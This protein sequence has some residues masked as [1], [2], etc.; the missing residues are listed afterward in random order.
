MYFGHC[1]VIGS[2]D[3]Q[4]VHVQR[5][6]NVVVPAALNVHARI[7]NRRQENDGS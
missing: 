5:E 6:H 2:G 1:V 4:I 3:K 7:A